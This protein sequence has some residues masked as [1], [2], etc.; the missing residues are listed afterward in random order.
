MEI[1]PELVIENL[2]R[3]MSERELS[4]SALARK[5]KISP[6]YMNK[7]IKG[8]KTLGIHTAFKLAEALGCTVEEIAIG[9]APQKKA[10]PTVGSLL[11]ALSELEKENA[12]LKANPVLGAYEKLKRDDPDTA[13]VVRMNLG[14]EPIGA[15]HSEPVKPRK[16]R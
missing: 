9:K 4:Q 12:Q 13:R 1:R 15:T 2:L 16:K 14:L 5:A 8:S 3:L 6:I 11:Q 7:L 10:T